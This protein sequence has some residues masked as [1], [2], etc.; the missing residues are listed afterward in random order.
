M[1]AIHLIARDTGQLNIASRVICLYV[2]IFIMNFMA[3][4]I[5][6]YVCTNKAG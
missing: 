5:D 1:L 4:Y 3:M 2:H 6:S